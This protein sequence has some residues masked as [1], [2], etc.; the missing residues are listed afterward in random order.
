MAVICTCMPALRQICGR[1]AP[2]IFG[3]TEPHNS[4]ATSRAIG[5]RNT[6]TKTV[7]TTVMFMPRDGYSDDINLVDMAGSSSKSTKSLVEGKGLT[8]SHSMQ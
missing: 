2:R 4:Y 5:G 6:I 7:A 1:I 3:T 8:D